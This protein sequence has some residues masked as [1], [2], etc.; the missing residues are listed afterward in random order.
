MNDKELIA[1]LKE[2]IT[3][4]EFDTDCPDCLANLQEGQEL[5]DSIKASE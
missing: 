2:I 4:M 5:M 1:H 3:S